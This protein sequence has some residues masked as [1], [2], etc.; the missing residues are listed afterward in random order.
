MST[1]FPPSAE[2]SIHVPAAATQ[3][4]I[5]K[6]APSATGVRHYVVGFSAT[7]AA[8]VTVQTPIAVNLIAGGTGGTTYLWRGK[9]SAPASGVGAI[10]VTGINLP[11][12][13]NTA[14]TLE[15]AGAGASATE[16]AVTLW[17]YSG[18]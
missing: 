14:V 15:F 10:V 5:T 7:I 12:P 3:A 17:T 9:L 4:T 11:V 13:I 2:A 6:A 8:G 18:T 1:V 16:Q